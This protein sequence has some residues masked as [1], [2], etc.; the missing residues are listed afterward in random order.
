[1]GVASLIK[2]IR[3]HPIIYDYTQII[4]PGVGDHFSHRQDRLWLDK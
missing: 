1:M 2:R 4:P 3:L